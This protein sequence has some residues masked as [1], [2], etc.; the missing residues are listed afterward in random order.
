[1]PYT[2]EPLTDEEG[3]LGEEIRRQEKG[4]HLLEWS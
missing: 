1:M 4:A 2:D 3:G